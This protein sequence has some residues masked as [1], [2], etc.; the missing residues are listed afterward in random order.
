M[1]LSLGKGENDRFEE[2]KRRGRREARR[3]GSERE[4]R[5]K[6]ENNE[7]REGAS[8]E[9]GERARRVGGRGPERRGFVV[10]TLYILYLN[11][12]FH[13]IGKTLRNYRNRLNSL[14]YN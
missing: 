13:P 11:I 4:R 12:G 8:N 7:S 5:E 1:R 14:F 6:K 9:A 3:G 10:N 2:Q